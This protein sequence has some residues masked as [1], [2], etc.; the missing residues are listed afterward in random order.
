[1]KLKNYVISLTTATN[2]REHIT[3]E[4]GK[5]GIEFEFFDAIT[6]NLVE[7]LCQDF[8]IDLFNSQGLSP[9]EKACFLSH[10]AIMKKALDD[11]LPYISIFEDDVYLGKNAHLYYCDD[12]YLQNSNIHFLKP[13]VTN[14][15]RK[16]DRKQAVYLPDNRI[17][18]PLQEFHLGT[19]NYIMSRIAIQEFLSYIQQLSGNKMLPIDNLLF[20]NFM[21]KMNIYQLTPAVCI[22]EC[23]LYPE[24]TQLSSVLEQERKHR[25]KNKPK[26]TL[27]QKI[28]GELS[29]AYRKTFGRFSRTLIEFR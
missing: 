18:Y 9:T 7:Q 13:E 17:A 6:P 3:S 26:R 22:Q 16:L 4:F 10:I 19:G 11:N 21:Q 1:M 5:Q 25:Q 29:N 15:I 27:S 24:T 14:P 12:D 2:R 28:K 20:D 8:N 23:I